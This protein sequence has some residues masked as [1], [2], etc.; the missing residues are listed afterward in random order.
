MVQIFWYYG[1]Y[2]LKNV[3]FSFKRTRKCLFL[4]KNKYFS[5]SFD[6]NSKIL[7]RVLNKKKSCEKKS[8]SLVLTSWRFTSTGPYI[9]CPYKMIIRVTAGRMENFLKINKRVYPSIWDLR[10]LILIKSSPCTA[11]FWSAH[12]MFFKNFPTCTFILRI[13]RNT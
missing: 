1:P 6:I 7:P 8:Q 4:G 3:L 10:V 5:N 12:L 9:C 2:F 11:L 13:L